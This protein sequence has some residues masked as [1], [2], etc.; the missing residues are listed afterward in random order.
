MNIILNKIQEIEYFLLCPTVN[1]SHVTM[2][3]KRLFLSNHFKIPS[4]FLMYQATVAQPTTAI[5]LAKCN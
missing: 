1:L 5:L 2:C 3:I 4:M